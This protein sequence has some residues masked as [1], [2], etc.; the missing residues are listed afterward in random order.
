[1]LVRNL[2]MEHMELVYGF[3]FGIDH[4]IVLH[5]KLKLVFEI[6]I[7][8]N[9]DLNKEMVLGILIWIPHDSE[10]ELQ[11]NME[12]VILDFYIL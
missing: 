9:S 2:N 12:L 5:L 7:V 1:M 10:L 8:L 4:Q 3:Q 6:D 11:L